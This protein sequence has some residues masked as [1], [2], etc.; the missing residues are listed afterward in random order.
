MENFSKPKGP[1]KDLLKKSLVTP[2]YI[3]IFTI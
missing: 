3:R 1:K 2:K